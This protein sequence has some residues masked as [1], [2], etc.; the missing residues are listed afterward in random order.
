MGGI[1]FSRLSQGSASE[2]A[3][4]PRRIFTALPS[5]STKYSY[6]RD[7]QSEVWDRWHQ[8][9][10]RSDLVIKMNTGGG[11]TVVGLLI[12][13]S[14]LNE[15]VDPAVYISP[16]SYLAGQVRAEAQ[17]LGIETTD[18]PR[19][20]RFLSGNAILVINLYRLVNGLSVFGVVGDS[21]QHIDVGTVLVDDAHA[22]VTT[23][24]EQFTL[25]VPKGHEAYAELLALLEDDLRSQSPPG[26]SDLK[27]GDRSVSM[28]IPY[29]SWLDKQTSVL[30]VLHPHRN[31][32]QFKFVWPLV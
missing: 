26:I 12:L 6:P 1:D 22:C 10:D 14:C 21:K 13:K 24:E 25:W 31:E 7:V 11:K 28:A 16:D 2:K 15:G 29:W 18:D 4:E 27:A 19:S 8:V 3:T 9:R 5:K 23:V 30:N 17:S 32:D 20:G